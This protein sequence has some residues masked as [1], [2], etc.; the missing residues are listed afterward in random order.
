MGLERQ[1]WRRRAAVAGDGRPIAGHGAI[2]P[3]HS[4]AERSAAANVSALDE[5]VR[6]S[7]ARFGGGGGGGDFLAGPIAR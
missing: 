4:P 3:A 5:L 6:R 2:A 1:R 7:R